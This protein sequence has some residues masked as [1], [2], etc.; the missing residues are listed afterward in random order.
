MPEKH[1][2]PVCETTQAGIFLRISYLRQTSSDLGKI[3]AVVI[4]ISAAEVSITAAVR[5][6]VAAAGGAMAVEGFSHKL[7]PW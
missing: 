4:K 2:V 6:T 7:F 1:T 3:S 5:K